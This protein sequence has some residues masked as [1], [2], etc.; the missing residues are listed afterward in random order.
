MIYPEKFEQK[1]EFDKI[2]TLIQAECLC[3][4][5]KEEI[6]ALSFSSDPTIIKTSAGQIEEFMR[7]MYET[8]N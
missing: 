2:K 5:G 7:L 3:E 1:I 4:M 8:S 6:A